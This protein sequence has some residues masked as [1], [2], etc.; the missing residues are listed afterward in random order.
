MFFLQKKKQDE[1]KNNNFTH[2]PKGTSLFC[3][4]VKY[5]SDFE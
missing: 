4:L 1:K 3:L 5:K 2:F